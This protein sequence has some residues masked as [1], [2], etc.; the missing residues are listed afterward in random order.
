MYK[1]ELGLHDGFLGVINLPPEGASSWITIKAPVSLQSQLS[2]QA[3][4]VLPEI[5]IWFA[6]NSIDILRDTLYQ[7]STLQTKST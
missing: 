1:K 2:F 4:F 7:R 5:Q 6:L 3:C